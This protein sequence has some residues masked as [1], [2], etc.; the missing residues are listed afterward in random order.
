VKSRVTMAKTATTHLFLDIGGVLLT[1]GWGSLSRRK[2][3][4]H[5]RLEPD[6]EERHHEAW[7]TY[8]QGRLSLDEYL[9]HVVFYR[10]RSFT[11][12]QF[13]QYMLTQSNPYPD[14]IALVTR[15]KERHGLN[16]A[17]I[18]NEGRELNG[19]RIKKIRLDAI[20]DVFISSCYVRLLKPDPDIYRLALDVT[21]TMPEQGLY[22]ENT[23]MFVEVA[24]GLGIKSIL[25]VGYRSTAARLKSLGL[26]SSERTVR[27]TA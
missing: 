4:S 24:E 21:Q 26:E 13:R 10:K 19:Y 1:D 8:Q 5:F 11:R 6:V 17:V 2:A 14:M 27:Q 7:N 25:H 12:T 9:S 3:A 23:P 22:I 18:S 20:A 15:V 16:V